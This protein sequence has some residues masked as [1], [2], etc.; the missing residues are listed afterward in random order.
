MRPEAKVGLFVAL[1][2]LLLFLLSTQVNRFAHVGKKG[3]EI[4]ALLQDASG[5]EKNAKVKI[6][7]VDVGYVK[8]LGLEGNVVK[9]TLFIYQGVKIPKDSVVTLQQK[10]LL[11]TKYLAII[12]GHSREY[13][14]QGDTIT[15]QKEFVSFDQTS[16]TINDA[17]KEFKAFIRDLR[18]S[19]AGSS[20]ED[21]KKSIENLRTITAQLKTLIQKNSDNITASIENIKQMG[22]KL[23]EAGEKFGRMSEKFSYTADS[24]NKKLPQI[25]QRIDRL[26]LY[27]QD[28]SKDIKQKL[29]IL[30]D[31]FSSIEDELDMLLKKNKKPLS[32][33]I[34][35][36]RDFFKS[37][38]S[39]FKKLDKYLSSVSKSK[40]GVHFRSY[41]MSRD[42]YT[43]N[44]FGIDYMPSPNKS[45]ILEVVSSDDYSRTD[46]FGRL[47]PPKTHQDSKYYVS[48]EYAKRY[49]DIRFRLGLIESTGGIGVDYYLFNDQG[50][51]SLDVF[52]FNAVNDVRGDNAHMSVLYRQR[53]LKHIDTYVG[54]DNIL[55]SKARNFIF[56]LGL[57]FIDEDMKYLLGAASGA[58]SYIK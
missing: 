9:A 30:M 27:L 23:R 21:L 33:A 32:Q 2:L 53:F 18:S 28:S 14:T 52:D 45:Y 49:G 41:Y 38:G 10:S 44:S 43:K 5:L 48:A 8:S 15:K 25:L 34:V 20:G 13:L 40:I 4:Y 3:Y 24:I 16:T 1:G 7:G 39:S 26:T 31:K 35:S 58:G 54:A 29:P 47:I 37:G 42:S 6:H 11:G 50:K 51:V 19:I 36:A 46:R 17:A 22:I 55:N 56:G 57:R 12:P